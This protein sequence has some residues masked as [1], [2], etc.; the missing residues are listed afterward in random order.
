MGAPKLGPQGNLIL[1]ARLTKKY[2]GLKFCDIDNDN[3]VMTVHKMIFTKRRGNN[4]Y[5]VFA[6]MDGF[7][8]QLSNEHDANDPYWQPWEVNNDLF[9][10]MRAYYIKNTEDNVKYYES[11]K[12]CLSDGEDE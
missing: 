5:H 11:G 4:A 12:G 3:K 9:D 7:N 8:C 10:C 1:E 6:T 2:Q